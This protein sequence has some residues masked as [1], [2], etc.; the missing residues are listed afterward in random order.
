MLYGSLDEFQVY[1]L[2]TKLGERGQ[3]AGL[4]QQSHDYLLTKYDR[5]CRD[6]HIY[7]GVIR[8]EGEAPVLRESS[9][10]ELEARHDLEP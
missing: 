7:L 3:S 9:L 4:S 10:I 2:Q 8:L 5:E 6:T 1:I